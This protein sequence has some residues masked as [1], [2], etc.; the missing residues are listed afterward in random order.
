MSD[1]TIITVKDL[2]Q[3]AF[4]ALL[5]GDLAERDR[6]CAVLERA[7]PEGTQSIPNDTPIPLAAWE[8]K[9]RKP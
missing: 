5:V 1:E 9:R 8:D 4:N 2:L 7:W 6:L 3:S